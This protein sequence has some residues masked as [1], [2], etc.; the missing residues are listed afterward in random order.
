MSL[1]ALI[2]DVDGTLADTERN[3]HRI[4]YNNT[5]REFGLD[6]DWSPEIYGDL[7]SVSGGKERMAYYLEKYHPG[8]PEDADPDVLIED[9]YA[10]KTEVYRDML[11]SGAIPLRPGV[12]RLFREARDTGLRLAIA[13]TTAPSNVQYLISSNLGEEALGWFD[14]IAAGEMVPNKKPSPEIYHLVLDKMGWDAGE[15]VAF[16]DS[17]NGI[18]SAMAAD[19]PV[20][21]TVTDYTS[22]D[23]FTGA[24][25][26]LSDF[27]E[28]GKPAQ[29]ISSNHTFS[30]DMLTADYLMQAYR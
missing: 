7:L 9:I 6:W 11:T 13:T 14:I 19:L 22:D 17:Y 29:L 26:V 2:F 25:L 16:E 5:F 18:L 1:K 8:I 4:A 21:I 23:D 30:Q 3:G 10:R 15:C 12:E 28:P 24:D 20:I 27:G